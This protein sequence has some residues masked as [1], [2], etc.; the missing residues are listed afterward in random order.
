[1]LGPIS[2]DLVSLLKDCYVQWPR[3]Q[4][5]HWVTHFFNAIPA[6]KDYS[7]AAFTRA[8]DLCGLQ[9]HLKV[10]GIFCRLYLRDGKEG[11]L[12]NLPLT[13]NY[14]NTCLQSYD[15]LQPFYQWIQHTVYPSFTESSVS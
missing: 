3:E 15:E 4:V 9:R 7:L 13:F 2:Y 10:L 8:F 6:P 14:L 5:L 1:M 12:K 11:Y